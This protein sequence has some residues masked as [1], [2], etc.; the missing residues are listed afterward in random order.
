MEKELYEYVKEEML[1][2]MLQEQITL[3]SFIFAAEYYFKKTY[4][5]TV[6]KEVNRRTLKYHKLDFKLEINGE[7]KNIGLKFHTEE[8]TEKFNETINSIKKYI[9]EEV[10]DYLCVITPKRFII[11]NMKNEKEGPEEDY[12]KESEREEYIQYLHQRMIEEKII[13]KVEGDKMII[14]IDEDE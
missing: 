9:K 12:K 4:K 13:Y 7:I 6:A 11:Y 10:V 5:N 8:I 14:K 1:K 2:K 3:K